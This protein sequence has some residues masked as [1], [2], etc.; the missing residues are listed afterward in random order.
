MKH[1]LSNSLSIFIF[2]SFA[3]IECNKDDAIQGTCAD[4][5]QNQ[6]ETG[7]DCGGPCAACNIV[8]VPVVSTTVASSVTATKAES[9]GSIT[10]TGNASV[11]A[12][13]VCWSTV[14][15]P[16]ISD[17]H[18]I[19]LPFPDSF[20]S[21][22]QNLDISTTYYVRA[23]A[24]NSAGVAYGNEITFTTSSQLAFGD[25]YAGGIVF[26]L[27]STSLHGYVCAEYNQSYIVSWGCYGTNVTGA[28]GTAVGT[29]QANTSAVVAAS[30]ALGCAAEIC[31]D[32]VLNGYSDWFLPSREELRKMALNLAGI[33]DFGVTYYWSSTQANSASAIAI[34][35]PGAGVVAPSKSDRYPIR[36]IRAF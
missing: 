34:S 20:S 8:L 18:T 9:G 19:D 21:I 2:F 35:F 1:S 33:T 15:N 6:G 11:T 13:G 10:S 16:T 27:D 7:V 22:I 5:I 28:G 26:Y 32:L 31:S 24:I 14:P 30:C 36:A 23:Y 17:S 12:A 25:M 3:L 4:R 29:G